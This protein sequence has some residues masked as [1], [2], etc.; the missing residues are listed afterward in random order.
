MIILMSEIEFVLFPAL[1][2]ILAMWLLEKWKKYV[3][4]LIDHSSCAF[5]PFIHK[6]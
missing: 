2:N 5:R 4:Y 1:L 6:I 3:A